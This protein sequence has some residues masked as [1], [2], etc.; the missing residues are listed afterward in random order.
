MQVLEKYSHAQKLLGTNFRKKINAENQIRN[1]LRLNTKCHKA[2]KYI[3]QANYVLEMH[4]M[5]ILIKEERSL[6][7]CEE[8]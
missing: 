8:L 6:P 5:I 2:N 4:I 7:V 3:R 1:V